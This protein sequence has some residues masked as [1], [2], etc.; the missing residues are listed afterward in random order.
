MSLHL[1]VTSRRVPWWAS[2]SNVQLSVIITPPEC[3]WD[4][5]PLHQVIRFNT[6]I[7]SRTTGWEARFC[8]TNSVG[9]PVGRNKAGYR[10]WG[11]DVRVGDTACD[12]RPEGNTLTG[13]WNASCTSF[14]LNKKWRLHVSSSLMKGRFHC[15]LVPALFR[16]LYAL[17]R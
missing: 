1:K 3:W 12:C 10:R 7:W 5:V 8:A 11:K 4:D 6:L 14:C 16:N 15:H 9:S 13:T 2:M 17:Y